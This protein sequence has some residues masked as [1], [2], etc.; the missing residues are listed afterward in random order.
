[1][2]VIV[3]TSKN[4]IN[5]TS[6]VLFLLKLPPSSAQPL[7]DDTEGEMHRPRPRIRLIDESK[8]PST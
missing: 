6:T 8:L 4:E 2:G 3:A 5:Y 1:M 7:S